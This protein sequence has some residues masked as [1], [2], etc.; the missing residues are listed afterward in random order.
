MIALGL[1]GLVA[2]Y[3]LLWSGFKGTDPRDEVLA[4]LRGGQASPKL[5]TPSSTISAGDTSVPQIGQGA[6]KVPVGPMGYAIGC[7]VACHRAKNA[8][9]YDNWESN[10]A[11]DLTPVPNTGTGTPVH[12]P[13]DG[14]I[15]VSGWDRAG[16]WRL[17]I[18]LPFDE[19]YLAHF[20]GY[21]PGIAYGSRVRKGQVI[22]YMG[23]TGDSGSPH[24]HL[25]S[26]NG[27]PTAYAGDIF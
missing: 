24:V 25:S 7:D 20:A 9:R 3:V 1:V 19:L 16:G 11:L 17:H 15:T 26:R 6:T 21:A 14:Q 23:S 4:A 2:A 5:K 13:A 18:A 12:A 27:N 22:A 10:N 8:G